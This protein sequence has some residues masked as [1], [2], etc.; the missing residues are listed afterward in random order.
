MSRGCSA[1]PLCA[2]GLLPRVLRLW[3]AAIHICAGSTT[4]KP[5]K[6]PFLGHGFLSEFSQVYNQN[7]PSQAYFIGLC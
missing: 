5:L 2:A 3:G 6:T 7:K 1:C 4:S